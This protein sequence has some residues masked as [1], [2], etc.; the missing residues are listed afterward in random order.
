MSLIASAQVRKAPHAGS[1]REKCEDKTS[2]GEGKELFHDI[3]L[4]MVFFVILYVRD[5]S[6]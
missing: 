3:L 1:R 6:F 5:M 2:R 4:K